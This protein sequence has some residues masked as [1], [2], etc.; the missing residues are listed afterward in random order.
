[1]R[2]DAEG[3]MTG[4]AA[5]VERLRRPCLRCDRLQP[6]QVLALG[7]NGAGQIGVGA[8][9]VLT[10]DQGFM[11]ASAVCHGGPPWHRRLLG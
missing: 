4:A 1:M 8:A 9:A 2:R 10:G 11:A 7:V 5:K 6:A 3:N